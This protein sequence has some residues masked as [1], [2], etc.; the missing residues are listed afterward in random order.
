M[1]SAGDWLAPGPIGPPEPALIT[2]FDEGGDVLIG[3]SFFQGLPEFNAG[4]EFEPS[5]QFRKRDWFRDPP[6]LSLV[7]IGESRP[8]PSS[9]TCGGCCG[10][11]I[12][13]RTTTSCGRR[14]SSMPPGPGPRTGACPWAGKAASRGSTT[15]WKPGGSWPRSPTESPGPDAR[16]WLPAAT[17]PWCSSRPLWMGAPGYIRPG[18]MR[19]AIRPARSR[20]AKSARPKAAPGAGPRRGRAPRP[21]RSANP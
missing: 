18:W 20:R 16:A 12:T 17:Q 7:I 6:G 2:G 14:S 11:Q 9:S 8:V 15:P 1:P 4:V 13:C 19:R 3:W 10:W 21:S 5:G